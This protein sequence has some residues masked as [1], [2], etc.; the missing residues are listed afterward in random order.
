MKKIWGANFTRY[1]QGY[2]QL[3]FLI[4]SLT[5]SSWAKRCSLLERRV[6]LGQDEAQICVCARSFCR[7]D[8]LY[9]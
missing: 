9:T 7:Y 6:V 4:F 3:I 2:S 8:D 5:K 1:F